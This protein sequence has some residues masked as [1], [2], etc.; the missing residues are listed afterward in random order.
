MFSKACEYAIRATI[1]IAKA[2]EEGYR[3]NVKAIAAQ[4]D[5]PEAFTAKILQKLGHHGLIT[6]VKGP[7]GGF[8]LPKAQARKVTLSDIVKVI[9]DDSIYKGC[10]LGLAQC[11]SAKPCPLHDHFLRI[12]E[13][14]R[15]MLE[16]TTVHDLMS[17]LAEGETFLKR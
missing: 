7:G 6:S 4:T 8:D 10:A 9:D 12:R 16:G 14:L 11:N 2:S 3:L 13:D 15:R 17:G 1:L 5:S